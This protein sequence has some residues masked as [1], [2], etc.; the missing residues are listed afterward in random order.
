MSGDVVIAVPVAWQSVGYLI[1][2]VV[3]PN[4]GVANIVPTRAG[5]IASLSVRDGQNILTGA[6][7][8]TPAWPH[9][10]AQHRCR[11]AIRDKCMKDL[12]SFTDR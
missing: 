12:Q 4:T 3:T 6:A 2:S 7:D 5:V 10:Q 11:F 9:N 1:F 8:K